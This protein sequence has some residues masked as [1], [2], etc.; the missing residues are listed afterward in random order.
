MFLNDTSILVTGG[1]GFIGSH[2]VDRLLKRD[3]RK[4]IILDNF[5]RGSKENLAWA[6]QDK[7]VILV[8]GDIR[9]KTLVDTLMKGIDLVFHEAALKHGLCTENPRLG[10]ETL[11]DGTF[12]VF[13]AAVKHKV[14]KIIFASSASVYGTPKHLPMRETDPLYDNTMYGAGKIY[15]ERLAIAYKSIYDFSFIGLR[16]F[17]VYGPRMDIHSK[18]TEVLARW[19]NQLKTG[20]QPIIFGDG[21]ESLDFVYVEDVAEAN[22]IAVKSNL[23][24][25]IFNIG[26]GKQTTLNKL[27]K[28]ILL[29]SGG[30]GKPVYK[31]AIKHGLAEQRQADTRLAQ[32]LLGFTAKT[33]LKEGLM[34]LIN[35][36]RSI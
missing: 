22:I 30:N 10:H 34:K 24:E 33:P 13:E 18:Y 25:G 28:L 14:K 23:K 3:I 32:S 20:K 16:Y 21:R 19:L 35:W 17:N 5:L 1:A 8:K 4:I 9:E 27:L 31:P 12:N 6:L 29:L 15:A 2:I 11:V 7:R 36:Y 26:S